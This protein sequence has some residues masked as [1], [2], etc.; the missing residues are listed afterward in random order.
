MEA[1]NLTQAVA[2]VVLFSGI[3]LWVGMLTGVWKYY[4]IRH[5]AQARA[6]Y[7]VDIAHRSSLLYAP[8]SLIIAILAHFSVW[9]EGLNFTFVLINLFFFSFSILSYVLHG[10][11]KDTT[12]QFKQPH[13][14]GRWHLPK[15][16]LSSAMTFLIIGELGATAGLLLGTMIGLVKVLT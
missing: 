12:N 7:Y 13:Q 15:W 5:S 10:W 6:H 8:A 1:E 16:M 4:Q 2:W 9:S 3:F 14:M 11:L